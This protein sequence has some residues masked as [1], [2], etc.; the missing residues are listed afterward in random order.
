[1]LNSNVECVARSMGCLMK[2]ELLKWGSD[3]DI[4]GGWAALAPDGEKDVGRS[5]EGVRH[6][7]C[8]FTG[9]SKGC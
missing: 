4:Q 1:M 7:T 8:S 5:R 3:V 2:G 9:R 6:H